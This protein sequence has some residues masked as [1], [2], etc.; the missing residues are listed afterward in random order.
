M[1]LFFVTGQ[2]G[3]G[4]SA[5]C[6]ELVRRG[7]QALDSDDDGLARWV[8][9]ETGYVHPKSSVK[10][11]A[12]TPEFLSAHDWKIPRESVEKLAD[13]A[14]HETV[15]LCGVGGN[16]TEIRDLFKAMFALVIDDETM[17]H[18]LTT[19]TTNNWGKQAH[20]LALT[21]GWQQPA[22]EDYAR[23]GHI[24]ID[25]TQPLEKVVDA[26]VTTAKDLEEPGSS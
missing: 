3:T 26:I 11:E 10:P 8:N 20:E 16:E 21:L 23:Y 9:K 24:I 12:R 13:Q 6:H 2:A 18:R 1:S 5:V 19:R 22:R 17:T 14:T 7:Y 25:A 4:K 15:F